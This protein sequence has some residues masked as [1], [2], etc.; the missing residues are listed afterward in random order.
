M[1]S[2]NAAPSD[3]GW[4]LI[5]HMI[6]LA[7]ELLDANVMAAN[8]HAPSLTRKAHALLR[9]RSRHGNGTED[10]L[11]ICSGASSLWA[12]LDADNWRNRF[13]HV[14][15]W[16]IDSFWIDHIPRIGR[17]PPSTSCSSHRGKTHPPGRESRASGQL[18]CHGALTPSGKAVRRPCESGTSPGSDDSPP[19]GRTMTSQAKPRVLSECASRVA[20]PARA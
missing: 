16:I 10:C 14:T 18:G 9:R 20:L 5:Q 1:L 17:L 11:L 2:I 7:G 8:K 13:R 12:L 6:A 3:I 15:A 4:S 19:S